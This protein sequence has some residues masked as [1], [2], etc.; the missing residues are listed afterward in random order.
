MRCAAAVVQ[1]SI[2]RSSAIGRTSAHSWSVQRVRGVEDGFALGSLDLDAGE[3]VG[4]Q[5]ALLGRGGDGAAPA[6]TGDAAA[7]FEAIAPGGR[8][9]RSRAGCPRLGAP[10]RRRAAIRKAQEK[11]ATRI[12]WRARLPN[13]EALRADDDG[14][15]QSTG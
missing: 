11:P 9:Q 3:R 12:W 14:V 4:N 8:A 7:T 1:P 6:R 15:S 10:L 13:N 2:S 5:V